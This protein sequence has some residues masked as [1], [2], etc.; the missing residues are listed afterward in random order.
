MVYFLQGGH[1]ED[2]EE[3]FGFYLDTLEEELLVLLASINPSKPASATH[4]M[5]EHEEE[6]PSAKGWTEVGKRNKMILT[7][8]VRQIPL[9]YAQS[10]TLLTDARTRIDQ[11]S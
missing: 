2:A 8:T 5:E 3:F 10:L 9:L 6:T 11:V 1:Q 7:R 4:K